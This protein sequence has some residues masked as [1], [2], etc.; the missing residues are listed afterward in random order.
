MFVLRPGLYFALASVMLAFSPAQALAQASAPVKVNKCL[1]IA[2]KTTVH[3][4]GYTPAYYPSNPYYWRD[5][6][7]S[8]YRQYPVSA[9]THT[10]TPTLDIDY[11]NVTRNPLAQI[12]FG[13]LAKGVLVAE[14]RDVGTFSPGAE[15]KHSF[16]LNPN[17]FPLGTGLAQCVPLHATYKDGTTWKNPHLPGPNQSIYH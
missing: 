7:G 9:K 12:D 1:P 3:Y 5:P 4:S 2:P 13:L 14:V 6:Y 10:T 16:G 8:R 15:I 17:V 11:V